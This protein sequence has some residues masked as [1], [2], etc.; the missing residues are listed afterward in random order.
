[1]TR[2]EEICHRDTAGAEK[3]RGKKKER[4]MEE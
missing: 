2:A 3:E 1:M 4:E